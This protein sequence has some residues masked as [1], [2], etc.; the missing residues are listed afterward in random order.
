M[1]ADFPSRSVAVHLCL[2]PGALSNR[3]IGPLCSACPRQ[4][5]LT[6]ATI[7]QSAKQP[8]LHRSPIASLESSRVSQPVRVEIV[9]EGQSCSRCQIGHREAQYLRGAGENFREALGERT[10]Q[11]LVLSF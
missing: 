6:F 3:S 2:H 7:S 1:E 5:Q 4:V 8:L 9:W 11:W 10:V